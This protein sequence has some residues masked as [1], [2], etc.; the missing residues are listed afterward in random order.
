M[1]IKRFIALLMVLSTVF[2]LFTS[3]KEVIVNNESDTALSAAESSE[4]ESSAVSEPERIDGTELYEEALKNFEKSENIRILSEY[5]RTITVGT[6][7][8]TES[9]KADELFLSYGKKNMSYYC[10]EEIVFNDDRTVHTEEILSDGTVFLLYDGKGFYS[11]KENDY[12]CRL[13]DAGLYGEIT[14]LPEKDEDG[15]T[16]ITFTD[17]EAVESWLAYDYAVVDE[18][19]AEVVVDDGM[20]IVSL[21]YDVKY[22]QGASYNVVSYSFTAAEV[23]TPVPEIKAPE[24]VKDYLSVDSVNAVVVMDEALMNLS[25]LGTYK[26]ESTSLMYAS[27]IGSA[28]ES[29]SSYSVFEYGGDFVCEMNMNRYSY[30]YDLDRGTAKDES[31]ESESRII[32]GIRS[33]VINGQESE[34]EVDDTEIEEYKESQLTSLTYCVPDISSLRNIGISGMDGYITLTVQCNR[35]HGDKVFDCMG[36]LL[37]NFDFLDDIASD[38]DTDKNEFFITVDADTFYPTAFGMDYEGTFTV[39]GYDYEVGFERNVSVVPTSPEIYH[40]ITDERHP[41][42]DKEPAEEDKAKPLFYKVT[43]TNGNIMWLLGTIHIGDNRTGYLPDEI[44][45]AFDES[46]AV[47]FEIDVIALNEAFELGEDDDLID[48]YLETYYYEDDTIE[49]NIDETLYRDA[50]TIFDALGLGS[51]GDY[52][53]RLEYMKPNFWSSLL[54]ET[55]LSHSLGVY[56]SD[57]V[58]MRLLERAKADGKQIYELEDRLR[59]FTMENGFSESVHEFDLYSTVYYPRSFLR[60]DNTEMFDAW[61]RGDFKQLS[62]MV[63]READFTGMSDKEIEAYKEY[64]K[65]LCDDRDALMLEKAKEYIASGETVF[66]AVGLAHLIDED[67]GLLDAL[68]EAGYTVEQVEYK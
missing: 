1:K 27:G 12:E 21:S 10:E 36:D 4:A 37:E 22:E 54:S 16:V 44:Y 53:N 13:L 20:N 39:D 8:R 28:E 14:Q 65:A 47:A 57:G 9:S 49:D 23:G 19:S 60:A 41:E 43:D 62:E 34:Y 45:K 15:N 66:V 31:V 5:E 59:Q 42:F 46:D 38:F 11:P 26:S 51:Y 17:A 3:C 32:D 56:Y 24:N 52:I 63:N 50:K 7:T 58:D 55:Y 33:T 18:A 68:E 64:D 35:K 61:C 48:L 29:G 30:W 25:G 2:A 40:D 6:E 67:T